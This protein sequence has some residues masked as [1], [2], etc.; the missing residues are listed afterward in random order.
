[1]KTSLKQYFSYPQSELLILALISFIIFV[2]LEVC[3]RTYDLFYYFSNIDIPLH[4][5]SG[6]AIMIG[7]LWVL[8]F[9]GFRAISTEKKRII[10]AVSTF[11]ISILW[12]LVE[13]LQE[14]FF[15]DPDY[16]KD[17]FFW[18]GFF[19]VLF[20]IVGA[21]VAVLILRLLKNKTDL[22]CDINI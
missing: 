18:D 12:E 10:A 21:I 17:V 8:N 19:D 1:M 15:T 2:L 3:S 6:F 9:P 13:I 22:F 14:L 5:L 4:I 20:S 11:I 16:L 7:F